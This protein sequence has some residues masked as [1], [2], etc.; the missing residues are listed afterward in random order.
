MTGDG[1]PPGP[2]RGQAKPLLCPGSPPSP[3]RTT[4]YATSLLW[5]HTHLQRNVQVSHADPTAIIV[6]RGTHVRRGRQCPAVLFEAPAPLGRNSAPVLNVDCTLNCRSHRSSTPPPPPATTKGVDTTG[7]GGGGAGCAG[8]VQ[9]MST[10]TPLHRRAKRTVL[11]GGIR[12]PQISTIRWRPTHRELFFFFNS[13]KAGCRRR[14][15]AHRRRLTARRL[16]V[17]RRCVDGCWQL[18]ILRTAV[19]CVL[20]RQM[21]CEDVTSPRKS[22][23]FGG[24]PQTV[25]VQVRR[26]CERPLLVQCWFTLSAALNGGHTLAVCRRRSA[27]DRR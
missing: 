20:K 25:T 27:A 3:A 23:S 26:G 1:C 11:G 2:T 5:T 4:R 24:F 16:M 8:Q 15:A 17:N 12:Q 22:L 21:D 7:P 9:G 6:G 14:F 10:G 19:R 13:R 18:F